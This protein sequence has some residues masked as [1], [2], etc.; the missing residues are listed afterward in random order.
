MKKLNSWLPLCFACV[1]CLLGGMRSP[2]Q[3]FKTLISFYGYDGQQ[4]VAGLI[5]GTDGN[6]YGTTPFGGSGYGTV[7][8]ITAS[9]KLTTL[10]SFKGFP[11]DGAYPLAGLTQDAAGNL[12]GT[13]SQGG[14]IGNLACEGCG[15]VFKISPDGRLTILHSFDSTDGSSP[16][17]ALIQ[18]TD[19][20]F[21][22]TTDYG[23][24]YDGGTAFKITPAGHLTTLHTVCAQGECADGS[25][26][27]QLLLQASNG[28]FYGTGDSTVFEMTPGGKVTTLYSF[29][30]ADGTGP[31]GLVQGANG[32]F[33]GITSGGGAELDGTVFEMTAAGKLTTLHSFDGTDGAGPHALVQGTDGNFYGATQDGGT[34]TTCTTGFGC[35][36]VFRITPGGK[37]TTLHSFGIIDGAFP[38]AALV[39]ATTGT[40]HG[41]TNG[42]G[43]DG[44]GTVFSLSVGLGPFVVTIPTSGAAGTKV[45]ILGNNLTGATSVTFNGKAATFKVVSSTE[46]TT[47]VPKGATTGKVS[48]KTPSRTLTSSVS[49]R[50]P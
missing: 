26:P 8:K 30:G 19:G 18:G 45:T 47:T 48:V 13:T 9:G 38:D 44:Y 7:F 16:G 5:Q 36:T 33:Y 28:D 40:F 34:S 41:T 42:G 14:T 27:G 10:H 24:A 39:Q 15:T 25:S 37:L 4:P 1:F 2:A 20:N 3:T 6:L 31:G 21:Y 50:V 49:F 35:G 12:Y 22:G 46:I 17:G 29:D 23:G 11:T 43:A 32:N